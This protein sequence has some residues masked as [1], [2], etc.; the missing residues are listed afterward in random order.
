MSGLKW[1]WKYTLCSYPNGTQWAIKASLKLLSSS[2]KIDEWFHYVTYRVK[3]V[4]KVSDNDDVD[5]KEATTHHSFSK[6]INV[7]SLFID[8]PTQ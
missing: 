5:A 4:F 3:D 6:W 2:F 7:S 1:V 8:M